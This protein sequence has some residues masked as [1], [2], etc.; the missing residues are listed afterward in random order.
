MRGRVATTAW[1]TP[2]H[3]SGT[4][5]SRIS[6]WSSSR[7]SSRCSR[8]TSRR[9]RSW[10]SAVAS[11]QL[12]ARRLGGRFDDS[13]RDGQLLAKLH[14]EDQALALYHGL[15]NVASDCAGQPPR[16]A[17]DPLPTRDVPLRPIACKDGSVASSTSATPTAP[18]AHFDSDRRRLAAI[19]PCRRSGKRGD[20]PL[21]PR[22]WA[23]ARLRQ[24]GV[25]A[26][27][28]DR[29]ARGHDDPAQPRARAGDGAALGGAQLLAASRRSGRPART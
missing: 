21:L 10:R 19:G 11:V 14:P 2:R 25:R 28:H 18:S 27:R 17:L 5:W 22:R 26:A 24:Q 1:R 12:P 9:P 7:T 4:V 8:P 15:V 16:F 13:H 3:G 23:H 20:R 29:L 6:I